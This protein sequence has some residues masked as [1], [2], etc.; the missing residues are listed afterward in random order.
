MTYRWETER[1][2]GL[3]AVGRGL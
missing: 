2:F 1:L 3:F